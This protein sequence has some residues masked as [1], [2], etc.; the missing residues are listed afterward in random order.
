MSEENKVP[1]EEN[2]PKEKETLSVPKETVPQ[3]DF[4]L[5]KKNKNFL[6]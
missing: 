3:V 4:Y 1:V 6:G 2:K 5:R